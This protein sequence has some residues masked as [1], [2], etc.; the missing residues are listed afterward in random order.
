MES[1]EGVTPQGVNLLPVIHISHRTVLKFDVLVTSNLPLTQNGQ[2]G[3]IGRSEWGEW[4]SSLGLGLAISLSL[5]LHLCFYFWHSL[6]TSPIHSFIARQT[7][8]HT[9]YYPWARSGMSCLAVSLQ[10]DVIMDIHYNPDHVFIN[11]Q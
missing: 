4:G 11:T 9:R 8:L 7:L 5:C 2:V 1:C 3:I 6:Y 10:G